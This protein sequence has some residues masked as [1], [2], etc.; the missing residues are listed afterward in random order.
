[1][2]HYLNT[3]MLKQSS[4]WSINE[5]L[6]KFHAHYLASLFFLFNNIVCLKGS[7]WVLYR[8]RS[9]IQEAMSVSH[10]LLMIKLTSTIYVYLMQKSYL[11]LN[12]QFILYSFILLMYLVLLCVTFQ[13]NMFEKIN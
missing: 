6:L 11:W 4:M 8:H 13:D 1:M 12:L 3:G 2:I 9:F 5:H 10:C 7:K